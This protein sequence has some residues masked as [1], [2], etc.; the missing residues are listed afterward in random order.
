VGGAATG[1]PADATG[2]SIDL[3]L[4]DE[5]FVE[6]GITNEAPL[7]LAKLFDENGIN[8]TGNSIGH[9]ITAV[10]DAGTENEIVLNDYYEA[11][12]DTWKSGKVRY[13]LGALSEGTHTLSLKAWDT[14]N[15]SAKRTTEFVVAASEELAIDHVL[16][17]PNPFTTRTEFY[18]EHN[19]PCESLEVQVQV[20]TVSGRLV[21][22]INRRVTCA[23]FRAEPLAWD[24]LDDAGDRLG[25]G[26]YV[27]R[28]NVAAPDGA[29]AE[30]YEKLVIL[31]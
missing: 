20:F 24:G 2:P 15:N 16:N 21:K 22:T 19:R 28:L 13:R 3:Y 26:V 30:K 4:N 31:R 1:I 9:D 18:F 8:T 12:L 6:G 27:Y 25:R 5:N 10:I 11:D 7:L 23:G 29:K 17:Y 14:H